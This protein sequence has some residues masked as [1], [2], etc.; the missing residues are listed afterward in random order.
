MTLALALT[1][2]PSQ[3]QT[4]TATPATQTDQMRILL[5]LGD[6][7]GCRE[8]LFPALTAQQRAALVQDDVARELVRLGPQIGNELR[9]ICGPSAVNSSSSLGGGLGSPQPTKSSTQFTVPRSRIDS[10]LK[11]PPK[12]KPSRDLRMMAF[13]Q[14]APSPS[15]AALG[16]EAEG[17]GV[18]GELDFDRRDRKNTP[19]EGSYESDISGVSVGVDYVRG[20]GI[21]GAFFG[22]AQQDG[23]FTQFGL[24]LPDTLSQ[25]EFAIFTQQ[26]GLITTVCGGLANAGTFE[27]KGTRIGGFAGWGVGSVGF[28]DATYNWTRREQQYARSV[29]AIEAPGTLE[30][31]D[32]VLKSNDIIVDDIFAGTLNATSKTNENSL[33]MRAGANLGN[34]WL[35]VG[36]RA[37][38]TWARATT[39]AFT[40]TG[41]S[42]V[43]NDV[44]P[45]GTDPRLPDVKRTLGGP[46]GLE[47]AFDDQTRKSLVFEAGAEVA[48]RLGP[49]VPFVSGYWRRELEDDFHVVTAHFA[50]DLRQS[51]LAF[52]FGNDPFDRDTLVSGF[53]VSVL[54]GDRFV[55]RIEATRLHADDLFN[56]RTL[57][58]QARV[59]F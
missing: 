45:V 46:I 10:R 21:V 49:I 7:V 34:R 3:A 54:G 28:V 9:A 57:A 12:G 27:H 30:F 51:P 18:F 11:T 37:I 19:F 17:I 52:D 38:L 23:D 48:V 56:S 22:R 55:A 8:L 35:L 13:G 5:G 14:V 59:R 36:P 2:R 58:L 40:E 26:P 16:V 15:L 33:S 1:A 25:Q 53:G 39:D 47:L 20:R 4:T 32:G 43:N 29:C 6:A 24:I 42:T 50:Q 31:V 44:S 41:R